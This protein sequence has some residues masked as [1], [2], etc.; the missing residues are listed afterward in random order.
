MHLKFHLQV[1]LF[2]TDGRFFGC[3]IAESLQ[4]IEALGM[5]YPAERRVVSDA[6]HVNI[7]TVRALV[8]FHE[9]KY[10]IPEKYGA[11]AH[12]VLAANVL[13]YDSFMYISQTLKVP[14]SQINSANR[15]CDVK[16]ALQ[17]KLRLKAVVPRLEESVYC[18]VQACFLSVR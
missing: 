7:D 4:E 8:D 2:G 13:G 18:Y 11:L 10:T 9:D 6:D 5:Q 14:V 1:K 16:M 12:E 3:F 15:M 17:D